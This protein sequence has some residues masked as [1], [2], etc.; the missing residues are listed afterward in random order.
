[1]TPLQ[2]AVAAIL[3]NAEKFTWTTQG[4]GM[5]RVHVRNVG[6]IHIWD[7][8]LQNKGVSLL[9]THAWDLQSTIIFGKLFNTR[10]KELPEQATIGSPFWKVRLVCGPNTRMQSEPQ[11]AILGAG[12][13]EIYEP[14]QSYWQKADEIH[15]TQSLDGT[16]T[17]MQRKDTEGPGEAWVYWPNGEEFVTATPRAATPEEIKST[18]D[19]AIALSK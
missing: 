17:V 13:T 4:L 12:R 5:M 10:Y 3:D 15:V 16:V 11:R 9:H 8:H 19:R 1:M 18:I 7:S 14:M 2:I 6:R